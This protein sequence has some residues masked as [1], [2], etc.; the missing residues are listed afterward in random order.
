MPSPN[1]RLGLIDVLGLVGLVGLLIG[2]FVP[3]ATLIPFWGCSFR[4]LTGIACPGCGLTRV[5]DRLTH[6][7]VLGALRANPLG[8]VAATMFALAA[9]AMLAHLVFAVP[10]PDVE[11][12]EREWRRARLA[13]A[14]AFVVNYAYVIAAHRWWALP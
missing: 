1:R 10:L 4:A 2:R 7:N 6:L 14:L 12:T 11:L 5:A 8:T 13:A 3:L 9:V